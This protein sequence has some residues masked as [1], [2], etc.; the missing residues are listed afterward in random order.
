MTSL[1]LGIAAAL[2]VGFSK[3]GMPGAA[4]PAVALM[5]DAFRDETRLSVGAMLPLLIVGDVF[6]LAYYRRHA[7]WGRLYELFPFVVAGMVPGYLV[8]WL[9]H[10]DAL[11]LLLGLIVLALLA[12]QIARQR[13]K[14]DRIPSSRWFVALTGCLA[15]FGT[16]VGNAA[17]PVM[18]IYLI[19]KKMDKFEFLGT[20]AWFF[21]LVNASK[22][23]WFLLLDMITVR[24]LCFDAKLVPIV[25]VG[26]I[27]G[28]IF[29]QRIPQHI[30][31]A[32]VLL[33]AGI[34]GLRLVFF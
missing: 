1:L 34:A 19:S 12:L 16:T 22:I 11:R 23:P 6:A 27:V 2:L 9:A 24:T 3:T 14:W 18:S 7:D 31:N 32:L 30:F 8:L 17:G 25:V 29:L 20:S 4:I 5:A 26:A 21:F 10:G 15:G 13:F 33:L 28:A